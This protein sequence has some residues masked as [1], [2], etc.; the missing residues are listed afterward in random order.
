LTG[1]PVVTLNRA[2]AAGMANGPS[3]GLALLEEVDERLAGHYR[4]D[5][6]RAHLLEMSGD[7]EAA[8]TH[9]LAAAARTTNLPEQRYLI[10]QAA[11]LDVHRDHVDLGGSAAPGAARRGPPKR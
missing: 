5:A 11:R 4:L 3:A 2:V 10:S 1:N 9:Y 7:T 6:V 8:H